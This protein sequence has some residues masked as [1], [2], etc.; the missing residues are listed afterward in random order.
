M[1]KLKKAISGLF[2]LFFAAGAV[3]ADPLFLYSANNISFGQSKLSFGFAYDEL[4]RDVDVSPFVGPGGISL[5]PLEWFFYTISVQYNLGLTDWFTA[6]L[7]APYIFRSRTV[8]T[9]GWGYLIPDEQS[10]GF[11]PITPSMK[12]KFASDSQF[13]PSMALYLGADLPFRRSVDYKVAEGFNFNMGIAMSK[14][15]DPV[16][17]NLNGGYIIKGKYS[18]QSGS[19]LKPG[20]IINYGIGLELPLGD[21]GISAEVLG[22]SFTETKVNGIIVN[23]TSGNAFYCIPGIW[24]K[25]GSWKIQVGAGG[26]FVN[27]FPFESWYEYSSTWK[28]FSRVTVNL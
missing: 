19:T 24:F 26:S 17:M 2:I 16:E 22:Y 18:Y 11:A 12:I 15:I 9:P 7:K 14:F 6:S 27:D 4:S 8:T 13:T 1:D 21:F 28:I 10:S 23:N 25:T 5:V 3:H 20:N